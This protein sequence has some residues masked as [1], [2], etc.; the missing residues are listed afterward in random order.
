MVR[1]HSAAV[2]SGSKYSVA[3]AV[4]VAI[5]VVVVDDE[6]VVVAQIGTDMVLSYPAGC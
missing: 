4:F 6:L 3:I 2:D 1:Y 5:V